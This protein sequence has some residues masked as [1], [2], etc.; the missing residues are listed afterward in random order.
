MNAITPAQRADAYNLAELDAEECRAIEQNLRRIADEATARLQAHMQ[1][2]AYML[3]PYL[4]QRS[5]E[6]QQAAVVRLAPEERRQQNARLLERFGPRWVEERER[7]LE[8]RE[9]RQRLTPEQQGEMIGSRVICHRQPPATI[10]ERAIW[11]DDRDSYGMCDCSPPGRA[12]AF[13]TQTWTAEEAEAVTVPAAL[14]WV[15]FIVGVLAPW[16]LGAVII[17]TA[18]VRGIFG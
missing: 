11:P 15:I 18:V 3:N 16:A 7:W 5:M 13:R 17:G 14:M 4:L 9:R 10:R 2:P 12:A 8:E 1:A 6:M